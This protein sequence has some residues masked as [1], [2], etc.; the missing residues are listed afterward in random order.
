MRASRIK[1]KSTKV[2][3]TDLVKIDAYWQVGAP[4]KESG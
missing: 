3:V 4:L 1:L 2:V